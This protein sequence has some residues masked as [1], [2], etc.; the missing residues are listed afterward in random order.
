MRRTPRL[1]VRTTTLL[2]FSFIMVF[3][4]AVHASTYRSQAS[5]TSAGIT[6]PS[7]YTG[8]SGTAPPHDD[9]ALP[10]EP[11]GSTNLPP[12]KGNTPA[13]ESSP[14]KNGAGC[15]GLFTGTNPHE[16]TCRDSSNTIN[17]TRVAI[18]WGTWNG[19]SGFGWSKFYYYH[20][21]DMQAVIDTI[22]SATPRGSL[23][24]RDY[25]VYYYEA[26]VVE[27]RV[28]VVADVI[29]NTWG[30]TYTQDGKP[31][32]VL[33]GYCLTGRGAAQPTCPDWVNRTL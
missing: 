30:G 28:V 15:K 22:R 3:P 8:W 19:R 31:V 20:N 11:A 12:S 26:G 1:A 6:S 7:N 5:K 24:S 16:M 17:G 13:A 33:T 14:W 29:D 27:E 10:Q 18:R 25:E 4:T 9:G 32:G 23:T 21:L 2:I